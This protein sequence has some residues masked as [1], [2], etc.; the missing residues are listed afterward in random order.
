[1]KKRSIDGIEFEKSSGNVFADL[2]LP[3][4][5]KLAIKSALAIEIANAIKRLGISQ[6]EAARRMGISQPKVSA[7]LT[8]SRFDL[9]SEKK[10]MDGL[11]RLGYDIE[12]RARPVESA[13]GRLTF[14]V[15]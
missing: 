6:Q 11:T 3:D 8:G 10:L 14:A 7:L 5:E 9:L 2:E 15:V 12:I 13:A 4:A 1:M